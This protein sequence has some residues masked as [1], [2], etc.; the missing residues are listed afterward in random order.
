MKIILGLLVGASVLL[1]GT[2]VAHGRG[3]GGGFRGGGFSG[4]SFRG[5]GFSGGGFHGGGFSDRGFGGGGFSDRRFG[6]GFSD[7]GFGDG[8]HGGDSGGFHAGGFDAGGFHD[9]GFAAG[10]YHAG[11]FAGYGA[12]D[13]RLP[14][15]GAFGHGWAGAGLGAVGHSTVA[16]SNSV[17]AARGVGVRNA[18][19]DYGAFGAGWY[20]AHPGAWAAAGWTAGR[21]W[22]AATW[23]AVGAWCDWGA[24]VQPAQY[25]YGNNITYQGDEVYYG[26]QPVATA[27]EYYQQAST[28]A[29]SAPSPTP[30][31]NEWMPLG[32]FSLV[33]G[34]QTDS[35]TMFQLAISKSG[36]LAGNY[37]SVLTEATLPVHGAVQKRTQ[38]AAWTVGDN[39][40]TVYDAGLSSLTA[41]EA[42]LLLHFGKDRTQQW[43]L[44]R[45]E[46]PQ[47]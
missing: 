30:D 39:K 26:T 8:F 46:Q 6:G 37:Y 12:R 35:N 10:G 23:P 2:Q 22:D 20:G 27:D 31:S 47:K 21:A 42:P 45:L 44:V 25:L 29:Q 16:W 15:D 32:V 14:T 34:D 43:M 24:S 4:G 36:A 1:L 28:L 7:R 3:F 18:F 40:T 41:E 9:A 17:A 19:G 11:G 5:G 33:Q 13:F 38:R